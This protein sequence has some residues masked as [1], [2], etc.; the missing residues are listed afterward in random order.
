MLENKGNTHKLKYKYIYIYIHIM[1]K[2]YFYLFIFSE[3]LWNFHAWRYLNLPED[4]PEV[5]SCMHDW[6]W[7]IS[8]GSDQLPPLCDTAVLWWQVLV[9]QTRKTQILP[10][11]PFVRV[12]ACYFGGTYSHNCASRYVI[13]GQCWSFIYWEG[14]VVANMKNWTKTSNWTVSNKNVI[15]RP[16]YLLIYLRLYYLFWGTRFDVDVFFYFFF[17]LVYGI[18]KLYNFEMNGSTFHYS[19]FF[20]FLFIFF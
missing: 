1:E 10:Q 6:D 16:L 12:Q 11:N 17:F 4:G 2:F 5:H 18:M 14:S 15:K 3:K 9:R 8:R 7:K 20:T 13:I 19:T